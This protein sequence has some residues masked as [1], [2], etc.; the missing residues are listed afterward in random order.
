MINYNWSQNSSSVTSLNWPP[1][2]RAEIFDII[3]TVIKNIDW[4]NN[5][6]I[7]VGDFN[8]DF[9]AVNKSTKTN[10]LLDILN[11]FQLN[12]VIE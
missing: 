2:T 6:I 8:C 7:L 4:E 11:L 1:N 12:Q 5:E 10:R 9:L 3:K